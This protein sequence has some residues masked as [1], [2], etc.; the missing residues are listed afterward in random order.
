MFNGSAYVV[1]CIQSKLHGGCVFIGFTF[2][3]RMHTR[4]QSAQHTQTHTHTHSHILPPPQ[5][6]ERDKHEIEMRQRISAA[7]LDGRIEDAITWTNALAPTCLE[8]N[9]SIQYLLHCQRFIELVCA[10]DSAGALEVGHTHLWP[11][12]QAGGCSEEDKTLLH[13]GGDPGVC[14]CNGVVAMWWLQGLC[15]CV[16]WRRVHGSMYIPVHT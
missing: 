13:V 11:Y 10:D 6:S 5:I 14:V 4:V 1:Y 16:V 3:Q 15:W 7:V 12:V 9:P 2:T 8:Q